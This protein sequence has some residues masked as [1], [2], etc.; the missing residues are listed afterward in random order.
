MRIS[1]TSR[2]CLIAPANLLSVISGASGAFAAALV[3]FAA[4]SITSGEVARRS[5]L[6][7]AM[8]RLAGKLLD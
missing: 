3:V 4:T 6:I 2:H 8:V 5:T 7:A 1:P